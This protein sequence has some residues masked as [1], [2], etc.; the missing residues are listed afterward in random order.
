MLGIVA[1]LA[2]RVASAQ[3]KPPADD[4]I[5]VQLFNYS[6]GPKTFFSV[7]NGSVAD[8]HQLAL[9]ALVTFLTNPFTVYNTTGTNNNMVGTTRDQVV[10]SLTVAQLTAAYGITDKIQIGANLPFVF[11]L[12]GRG[13]DPSTGMQ[14]PNGLQVTGLGDLIV[15]G[16]MRLWENESFRLAGIVGTSLPTS[17]GSDGSQ[18]IGD[19]LPTARGRL[20]RRSGRMA[21]CQP[22]STAA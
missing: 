3:A 10:Q 21:A 14:D 20:A 13:L 2:P 6:I 8:K 11:S 17:F 12:A 18:F 19:N 1:A 16:K 22:A 4:A 9:D 7:D 5:D 15:E